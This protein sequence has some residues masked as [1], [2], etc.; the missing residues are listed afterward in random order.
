MNMEDT[1]RAYLT[2]MDENWR[3][4]RNW[5]AE[6]VEV[7]LCWVRRNRQE[8]IMGMVGNTR[9]YEFSDKQRF[10]KVWK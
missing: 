6:T 3:T 4:E 9:H 7:R 8:D 1:V 10:R 2:G 5:A